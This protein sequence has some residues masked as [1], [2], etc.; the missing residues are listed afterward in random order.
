MEMVQ[1]Y[2]NKN[3]LGVSNSEFAFS[4]NDLELIFFQCSKSI[5]FYA[6]FYG[7][8]FSGVV[9]V[10]VKVQCLIVMVVVVELQYLMVVFF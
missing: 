7:G 1:N 8:Y 6:A 9:V 2:F 5:F 4:T 10:A 3:S